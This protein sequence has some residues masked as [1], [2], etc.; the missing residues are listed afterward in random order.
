[1]C[2]IW[3]PEAAIVVIEIK[4]NYGNLNSIEPCF[5]PDTSSALGWVKR[6]VFPTVSRFYPGFTRRNVIDM[7]NN[8]T[9]ALTNLITYS[10][11]NEVRLKSQAGACR[12]MFELQCVPIQL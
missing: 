9:V 11:A 1:M 4:V 10:M 7:Q 3:I 5:D 6:D 2:V 12:L 8:Q